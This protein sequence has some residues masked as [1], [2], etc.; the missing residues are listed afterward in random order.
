ML[1]SSQHGLYRAKLKTHKYKRPAN[2][3][4]TIH[5][6]KVYNTDIRKMRVITI[7]ILITLIYHIG[8]VITKEKSWDHGH[9]LTSV[10]N[11][12][13]STAGRRPITLPT[14][15]HKNHSMVLLKLLLAGDIHVEQNPGSRGKQQSIYP[16]GL[17][18]HPVIWNCQ[19]ICCD[20]CSIWHHRSCIE[21]CSANYELLQKPNMRWLCCKCESINVTTF[22]FHSYELNTSNYYDP[23][24]HNSTFESVTSNAFSPLKASSPTTNNSYNTTSKMYIR[25]NRSNSSNVFNLP[26]KLF[27]RILTVNCRSIKD[28]TSEFT[29]AGNYIKP[30]IICGTESWLK[31]EKPGKDPT[32]DAIK[33]GKIFPNNYTAYRNDR[34]TLARRRSICPCTQ[35]HHRGRKSRTSSKLRIRM[36]KD[37]T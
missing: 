16:C 35:R 26:A 24:T 22:T 20:D 25:K 8:T 31:G 15:T 7:L 23:L 36:G 27:L 11:N 6:Y 28:K 9:L 18:D 37:T 34:G 1:F 33:S 21:L 19:G 14:K 4:G 32:K 5:N 13:W 10:L 3:T 2:N 17:C 29:A 12:K 30:D